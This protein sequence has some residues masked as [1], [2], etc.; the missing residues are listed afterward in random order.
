L[1]VKGAQ[2]QNMSKIAVSCALCL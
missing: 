1:Q 2:L